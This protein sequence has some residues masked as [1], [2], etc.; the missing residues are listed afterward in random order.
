MERDLE[1][2]NEKYNI[3]ESMVTSYNYYLHQ[4][5]KNFGVELMLELEHKLKIGAVELS[6]NTEA[7]KTL[8][9]NF[10]VIKELELHNIG[11]IGKLEVLNS[12]MKRLEL[13]ND[14]LVK[15]NEKLDNELQKYKEDSKSAFNTLLINNDKI[16]L[17]TQP[18]RKPNHEGEEFDPEKVIY[19]SKIYQTKR[20]MILN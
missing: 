4:Y 12:E 10:S 15:N 2:L 7:M 16:G 9:A 8:F 20:R 11:N 14:E 17:K 13:H 5:Q 19:Y 1:E 3:L 18:I 6:I